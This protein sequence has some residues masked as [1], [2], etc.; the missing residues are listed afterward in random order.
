MSGEDSHTEPSA[1]PKSYAVNVLPPT[2]STTKPGNGTASQMP[3]WSKPA[4]KRPRTK[5]P[6]R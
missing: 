6:G 4:L 2:R 5:R 3:N 1:A